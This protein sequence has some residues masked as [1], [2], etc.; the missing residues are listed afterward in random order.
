[1]AGEM[2]G[3]QYTQNWGFLGRRLQQHCDC[4]RFGDSDGIV[5][6]CHWR[7]FGWL[8]QCTC[9]LPKFTET[10]FHP[11]IKSSCK[12][13]ALQTALLWLVMQTPG[14]RSTKRS[15]AFWVAAR[16][17]KSPPGTLAEPRP[18]GAP[19]TSLGTPTRPQP[20]HLARL[21]P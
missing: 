21:H 1:M 7:Y 20:S 2:P 9:F 17:G 8:P 6:L 15:V 10:C 14:R 5:S 18:A 11:L 19:A 12:V 13:P 4:L 3:S 16:G